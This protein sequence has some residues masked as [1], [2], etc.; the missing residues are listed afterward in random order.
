MQDEKAKRE[1]AGES[2]LIYG[3]EKQEVDR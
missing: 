2:N 3:L 1:T